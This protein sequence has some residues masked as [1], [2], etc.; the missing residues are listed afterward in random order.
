MSRTARHELIRA[1]FGVLFQTSQKI[2]AFFHEASCVPPWFLTPALTLNIKPHLTLIELNQHS[3]K[4]YV[5][6]PILNTVWD[7]SIN[8]A[9]GR[10]TMSAL[11]KHA[12]P[13]AHSTWAQSCP[14]LPS[15]RL[16]LDYAA[17]PSSVDKCTANIRLNHHVNLLG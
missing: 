15:L 10:H 3:K 5:P 7:L 13:I 11:A 2:V 6:F 17:T 8:D 1:A 14:S 16:S 9:N 12:Q 4:P